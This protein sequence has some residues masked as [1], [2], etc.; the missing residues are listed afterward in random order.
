MAA[1]QDDPAIARLLE[2][3]V[4]GGARVDR[5]AVQAGEIGRA[6]VAASPIAAG[7][8][9]MEIPRS[10][11]ITADLA[12]ASP[13]G[14]ALAASGVAL[15]SKHTPIAAYLLEQRADPASF[16]RPYL[17]AL[18]PSFPASPVLFDD[19]A[20]SFLEG[21]FTYARIYAR[22]AALVTEYADLRKAVAGFERFSFKDFVW[23]R[24]VVVSR[25]FGIEI[26]GEK[27]E[28]LIPLADMLNHK[29][30]RETSWTYHDGWSAFII[31]AARDFAPGDAVHDSYGRKC[32]SRFFVNYGFALEDNEDNE[33]VIAAAIDDRDP[34]RRDKLEALGDPGGEP[35]NFQVPIAPE[36][37][38]VREMLSYFRL[39][40][41][42]PAEALRRIAAPGFDRKAVAPIDARSEAAALRRLEAACDAALAR[43]PTSIAEDDALLDQQR[44]PPHLR[45]AVIMRRGEK[46]VL[47]AHR[48]LGRAAAEVLLLP[49]AA[50]AR[51]VLARTEGTPVDRYLAETAAELLGHDPRRTGSTAP[52]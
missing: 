42:G 21:S 18:P 36:H 26:A 24:Q 17:D 20:L 27:T 4:R 31:S 32:N 23:A 45:A 52:P 40:A 48:D 3:L 1:A 39:A 6:A 43:F 51:A 9:V 7:E 38:T 29:R 30:P 44:L 13:I 10:F 5:V 41:A 34:I 47:T 15:R 25:V 46:R 14:R 28:A 2:W 33:A 12:R 11:L 8:L 16:F 22:R 35:R 50:L 49:P 37:E 19:Y